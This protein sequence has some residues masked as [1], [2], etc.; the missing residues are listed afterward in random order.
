M[1]KYPKLTNYVSEIDQFLQQFDQTHPEKS[2]SQKKE[3]DKYQHVYSLRDTA[4]PPSSKKI[5]WEDF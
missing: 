5:L 4:E 2:L 1:S 3:I